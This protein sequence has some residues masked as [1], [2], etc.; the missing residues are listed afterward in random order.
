L[1][2]SSAGQLEESRRSGEPVPSLHSSLF[3]PQAES[4]LRTGIV[5]TAS[6]VLDLLG[7]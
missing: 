6:A 1:S 2:T 3:L 7:K 5:A 4:A